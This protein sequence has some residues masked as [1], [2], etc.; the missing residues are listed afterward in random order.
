MVTI[1]KGYL[2]IDNGTHGLSVIFTD[3]DLNVLA[4][5]EGSYGFV[6]DLE[7]GNNDAKTGTMLFLRRWNR[8]TSKWLLLRSKLLRL[9]YP[10]KCM[11]KCLSTNPASP[12]NLYDSGATL[13]TKKRVTSSQSFCRPRYQSV[14]PLL[15][16][17]GLV[18]ISPMQP[19]PQPQLISRHLPVG[20]RSA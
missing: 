11:V 16:S 9:E 13:V 20:W 5:G 6:D 19:Q 12:S 10:V 2:G 14:R 3:E 1:A 15:G 4:T 7:S 18:G 8:F 17:C